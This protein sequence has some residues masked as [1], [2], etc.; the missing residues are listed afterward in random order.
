MNIIQ[1]LKISSFQSWDRESDY[2]TKLTVLRTP[3]SVTL[4]FASPYRDSATLGFDLSE[5][6][7]LS[8]DILEL[9]SA[10]GRLLRSQDRKQTKPCR[11]D[12]VSKLVIEVRTNT[13]GEPFEEGVTVSIHRFDHTDVAYIDLSAD[14]AFALAKVLGAE[15]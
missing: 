2:R 3:E 9:F 6:K 4:A 11:T 10:T 14:A 12:E 13:Q 15:A 5:A 1:N 7:T 8:S